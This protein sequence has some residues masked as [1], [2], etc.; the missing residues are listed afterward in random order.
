MTMIVEYVTDYINNIDYTLTIV[1][2]LVVLGGVDAVLFKQH[3]R[4]AASYA[5]ASCI[6][7][8]NIYKHLM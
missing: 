2:M 8:V 5:L 7:L 3:A 1:G 4:A 6:L